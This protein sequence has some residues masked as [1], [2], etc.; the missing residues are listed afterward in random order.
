MSDIAMRFDGIVTV[1]AL[2]LGAAI[3]LLIALAALLVGGLAR[4]RPTSA[5]RVSGAAGGMCGGTLLLLLVAFSI[6]TSSG[7]AHTGTDWFDLLA[8]PW[9]IA[10][11]A[12]C[13]MLTRLSRIAGQIL[14]GHPR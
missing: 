3:Y 14:L 1:A 8:V 11:I 13:W 7:T 2:A 9:V 12:G 10:S 5:G 4:T 6:W